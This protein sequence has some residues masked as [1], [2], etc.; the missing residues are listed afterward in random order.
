MTVGRMARVVVVLGLLAAACGG[1]TDG[2]GVAVPTGGPTG[3]A[4]QLAVA[5]ASFD[6]AVGDGQRFIA[7]VLTP[8]RQLIARGTVEMTFFFLGADQASG[9]PEP[10]ATTTATFLPVPG[11]EPEPGGGPAII[12]DP[13]A[14]GVYRADVSFDR[15]GFWGV[16]VVA[17]MV[18]GET[19]RGSASF[20]VGSQHQVPAVGDPA[21]A[22]RNLTI[23]SDAPLAA[24]DSR[25][26]T[27]D[28]IPDPELHGITVATAVA[29][30]RPTVVVIST[31]VYCVSRFC[32]PITDA[33][34]DLATEYAD[35]AEFVHIEVWS[36]FE[37]STLNEAA[38]EWILTDQGGNEPWVFLI[39]TDGTIAARWD[40]VLDRAELEQLLQELPQ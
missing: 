23:D 40:N 6:L 2:D 33:V 11:K 39:G 7:G 25:A 28:R 15:A 5:V 12:D 26:G 13:A 29:Q 37:S 31:P 30:E 38:E 14:A 20:R 35:R 34:S 10:V 1:G 22:S 27:E 4:D 36:D 19:V 18:D 16:G 9:T 3:R 24:V 17:R 32:G 21:P 8:D